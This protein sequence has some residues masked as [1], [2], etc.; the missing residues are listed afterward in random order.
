MMSF[1]L[2]NFAVQLVHAVGNMAGSVELPDVDDADI[3]DHFGNQD[4][5]GGP[6]AQDDHISLPSGSDGESVDLPNGLDQC[7]SMDCFTAMQQ[8]KHLKARLD[9]LKAGLAEATSRDKTKLQYDCMRS[10]QSQT[11]GWRRFKIFGEPCCQKSVQQ[12]LQ[13][14][15]KTYLKFCHNLNEGFMDPPED[16]RHTQNQRSFSKVGAQAETAANT[17]LK[18]CHDNMAEHLAES[19]NFVKAKKSLAAIAGKSS[20]AGLDEIQGPKQ[21]KWLPPGTTLTELRDFSTSFNGEIRPPS[22]A[23]FSR[24]YHSQWQNFLKVRTERQ[25]SKC[26][27]CQKLK[28]WRR[29]CQSK[30]DVE[31]VQ[32]H[33]EDHISSMRAD[34]KADANINM[35]AQQTAKG[36]LTDPGQTI[37][38]LVIDGMDEAK[39]KIP[40]RVD[41][42]KQMA[43]LWRPECRFIGCLAEGLTE[44]FFIGDV[45]LIKDANMDLTIVSHVIH[46]AQSTFESRGL[47]LPSL[48]RLHSH[49]ASG[50]LKNQCTMKYCAWLCHRSMFKEIWLT[51]FRVGHSHGKIDQRFSVCRGILADNSNLETPTAFLN[52]LQKV[53]PQEG[54][55]LNL[56]QI[57]ATV[58]F[59]SFFST[60]EVSVSGHTQTK[61]K[62]EKGEEAVHTFIFVLR[63]NLASDGP[64]V[65][66]TFPQFP[67]HPDDVILG[68]RHYIH[69]PADSQPPQVIVP[70]T[71][72][73]TF[74]PS[75]QGPTQLCARRQLTD[76]QREEFNKT[77]EVV[78]QP[79]WCMHEASA[80][81]LQLLTL[82][83]EGRDSSW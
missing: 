72:M 2:A 76:R 11:S 14:S 4:E 61:S 71:L 27:D 44:N 78:S 48:L 54:R 68:C 24:V 12:V 5:G 10:W 3:L 81:L 58:D 64:P 50:E 75:G 15:H 47:E 7:C 80:Y 42:S 53:Q 79:P 35:I 62:T 21:V 41:A 83:E 19:D 33:L 28:A 39:F 17:L 38:S 59:Q 13:I 8:D 67:P 25:H 9:E 65:T 36:E 40:K 23:T 60:L 45:D 1:L 22:F 63:K 82:N 32:K 37:L 52:A 20:A 55:T 29:Q 70:H 56:E 77:A 43:A 74:D 49:N 18:W 31:L 26:A 51:Q 46:E 66:E 16:M 30:Q 73:A 69:S 57:H 34:R 6:M